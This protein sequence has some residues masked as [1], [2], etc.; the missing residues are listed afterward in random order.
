MKCLFRVVRMA[1]M[2]APLLM[3]SALAHAT[4]AHRASHHQNHM[5]QGGHNCSPG[6][7]PPSSNSSAS[8]SSA[9]SRSSSAARSQ[10]DARSTATSDS[11]S[12]IS[13]VQLSSMSAGGSA[14][15]SSQDSGNSS[16][17]V[18]DQSVHAASASN[19]GQSV[20][21]EGDQAPRIPVA[22]ALATVGNT[23]AACHYANGGA[24]QGNA[25]GLSLS[26]SRK[27][28]DCERYMLA[29]YL[30]DRGQDAA[31]DRLMCQIRVMRE[32]LGEDCLGLVHQI[33]L[34]HV[35]PRELKRLDFERNINK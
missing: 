30:Y 11:K 17:E 15:L 10:S 32:A 28:R 8:N 18:T 2:I 1:V 26:F 21:I 29:Q 34:I 31:G 6:A 27:D 14:T 4:H 3:G 35:D 20:N 16:S 5:C 24:G 7:S 12:S 23:T 25:F 19:L 13:G 22:S 33:Q 9:A